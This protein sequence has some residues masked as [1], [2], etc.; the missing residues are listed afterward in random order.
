MTEDI[1]FCRDDELGYQ[2]SRTRFV[3]GRGFTLDDAYRLAH[4]PLVAPEHPAVIAGRAGS[5]Y[6]MGRHDRMFSLVLPVSAS[7]LLSS[8]AY[9]EL[10]GELK[11]A[12]FAPKIAWSLLEQRQDRLHATICGSLS[13][14]TAPAFDQHQ[15]RA[16]AGL[17]P[18][19]IELRGLFSGNL[20]IG[21][22]Y[23]R[24]YP[25]QRNGANVCQQIQRVLDR[26]QTDLY[27]VGV[28]NLTDHLDAME[29]AALEK[30]LE[31]WWHRPLLRFEADHV[32]LLGATDDLALDAPVIQALS[33]TSALRA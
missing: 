8:D 29:A 18:V 24:V 4:L 5:A 2:R 16:L 11:A 15:R 23:L 31:R 33:L 17:G 27:L 12:C 28:F 1:S 26:P 32:W 25:E 9:Q 21:R 20:N 7:P 14:G 22:L 30:L 13:R 10:L 6:H 19:Q 3:R